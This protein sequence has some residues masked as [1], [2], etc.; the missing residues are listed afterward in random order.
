M[1]L[2]MI[3]VGK[4]MKYKHP[5]NLYTCRNFFNFDF[6]NLIFKS[7]LPHPLEIDVY[8]TE[9]VLGILYQLES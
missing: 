7:L 4:A 3:R 8:Q 1:S 5:I 6:Y 2:I 9:I